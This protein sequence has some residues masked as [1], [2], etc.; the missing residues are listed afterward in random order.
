MIIGFNSGQMHH[1][2]QM[3]WLKNG[4]V[5]DS[6]IERVKKE[7]APEE[8]VTLR[9]AGVVSNEWALDLPGYNHPMHDQQINNRKD[10]IQPTQS[11]FPAFIDFYKKVG[12]KELIWTMNTI[13]PWS[14]PSERALWKK[15][16]MDML[17]AL[18]AAGIKVKVIAMEN[19]A[20]MYPQ[21]MLLGNGGLDILDK[22]AIAGWKGI[23]K[24]NNYFQP[25]VKE[26]MRSY[27]EYIEGI[28]RE[29]KKRYPWCK[30]AISID[31]N[32]HLRGQWMAETIKEFK[33]YDIVTPHFYLS[34]ANKTE[35]NAIVDSKMAHAR[36]FGKDIYVTEWNWKYDNSSK[37][38]QGAYHDKYFHND[39]LS[40]FRANGAKGAFKHTLWAGA[41]AYG[42]MSQYA[43]S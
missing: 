4:F 25:I 15:R 6:F 31:D 13:S 10:L 34:P 27:Y 20:W 23:F 9:V 14:N 16:M 39:M 29:V 38:T 5:P 24:N 7:N 41:S 42:H 12:F 32:S 11:Y 36:S 37:D 8:L 33:F 1:F 28:S 17:E 21:C 19:E 40:A 18:K 2:A 30:I 43:K 22:F 35:L 3:E 26:W